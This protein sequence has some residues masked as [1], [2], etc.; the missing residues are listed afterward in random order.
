MLQI[1]GWLGCLYLV[2]KALEII[3]NPAYRDANGMMKSAAIW[4]SLLA[5]FG[6]FG[7]ALWLAAQGGSLP[8]KSS[9]ERESDELSASIIS[10]CIELAKTPEDAAK[11]GKW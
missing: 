10:Q 6:A 5:C 9:A 11:C 1:I 8:Q 2:V 4:A 3:A 7:F